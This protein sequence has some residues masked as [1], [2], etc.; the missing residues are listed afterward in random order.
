MLRLFLRIK[1]QP[2]I[3]NKKFSMFNDSERSFA[4][5][6]T[7]DGQQYKA[8]Y[9][10]AV[11]N[12][13][14]V[15]PLLFD[16]L[17]DGEADVRLMEELFHKIR[18]NANGIIS[19]DPF[20]AIGI[21]LSIQLSAFN[22]SCRRNAGVIYKGNIPEIRAVRD[23][24]VGEEVCISYDC[25]METK[26]QRHEELAKKWEFICKCERCEAGDTPEELAWLKRFEEVLKIMET[27]TWEKD[28]TLIVELV[29]ETLPFREKIEGRFLPTK[30]HLMLSVC[31]GEED[32]FHMSHHREG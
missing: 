17:F 16:A 2:D 25:E 1:S 3:V 8:K 29:V 19:D 21:G 15:M 30:T 27:V 18:I 6:M 4:D 7:D 31:G 13:I 22:H 24:A 26:E 20:S 12:V 28:A 5:L 23:I 32:V 14:T 10:D 11:R 9:R